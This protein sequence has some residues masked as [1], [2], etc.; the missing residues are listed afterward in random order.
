MKYLASFV[1]CFLCLSSFCQE[2]PSYKPRRIDTTLYT[3]KQRQGLYPFKQAVKI[4]IVSF[5]KQEM[6]LDSSDWR[7]KTGYCK[8]YKNLLYGLPI[9]N[10]TICL[11][12]LA[13]TVSL[14]SKQINKLSDILYNTCARWNMVE[15]SKSGCYTPHNAILFLDKDGKTFDYIEIC[16]GCNKI[17]HSN[18]QIER[19]DDCNLVYNDLKKYFKQLGLKTGESDFAKKKATDKN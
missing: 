16:F 1:L 2:A 7:F 9:L 6:S 11:A 15:I 12:K 10:D 14:S 17:K 13:Q 18:Q 8:D 5:D 4:K 19:F 3:L